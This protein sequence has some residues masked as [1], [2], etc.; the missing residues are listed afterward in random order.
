M[1]VPVRPEL[2]CQTS[3]LLDCGFD[4]SLFLKQPVFV[5]CFLN[6]LLLLTLHG[7]WGCI[8]HFFFHFQS[9]AFKV[10]VTN[11]SFAMR[12]IHFFPL[13]HQ[14]SWNVATIKLNSE[15][16]RNIIHDVAC[17]VYI[18]H[19]YATFKSF[20]FSSFCFLEAT[21]FHNFFITIF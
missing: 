19:S 2:W 3:I 14:H 13:Y 11:N 21:A 16:F 18:K 9:T 20:S 8:L 15:L 12:M 4:K 7:G 1:H 5:S 17:S 10:Q 6:V